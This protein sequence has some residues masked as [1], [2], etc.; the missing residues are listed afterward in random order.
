[1]RRKTLVNRILKFG[2]PFTLLSAVALAQQPT[3]PADP[4]S[5]VQDSRTVAEM[6]YSDSF[7]ILGSQGSRTIGFGSVCS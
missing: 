5:L 7:E 2:V 6:G 3:D 4:R 1:M